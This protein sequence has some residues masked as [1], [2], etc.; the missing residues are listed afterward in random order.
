MYY[1][2]QTP[3]AQFMRSQWFIYH[4]RW[5]VVVQPC[6]L[7]EG[8]LSYNGITPLKSQFSP[9]TVS[10]MVLPYKWT[11]QEKTAQSLGG[12]KSHW[13]SLWKHQLVLQHTCFHTSR[14]QSIPGGSL[15][16]ELASPDKC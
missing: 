13:K 5:Y 11:Q 6:K 3:S 14:L 9:S 1:T 2:G 4:L 8:F 16:L 7:M 12:M 10:L 15:L